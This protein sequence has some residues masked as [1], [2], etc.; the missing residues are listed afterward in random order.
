MISAYIYF[1][2]VESYLVHIVLLFILVSGLL[3]YLCIHIYPLVFPGRIFLCHRR[4]I[5]YPLWIW[6]FWRV[7]LLW[8]CLQFWCWRR[9]GNWWGCLLLQVLFFVVLTFKVCIC[10]QFYRM[11]HILF[12]L[13][14]FYRV[15]GKKL[16]WR[17][18]L[19]FLLLVT[20]FPTCWKNISPTFLCN[21]W[22]WWDVCIITGY[23][24]VRGKRVLYD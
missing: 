21:C 8:W 22:V 2:C 6:W 5:V 20:G 18:L 17:H 4:G 9:P 7:V 3:I 16:R 12:W 15:P 19:C 14:V 11:W 1:H 10:K 24:I 23:R 13:L